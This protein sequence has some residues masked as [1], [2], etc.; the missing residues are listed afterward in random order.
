MRGM[1]LTKRQGKILNKIVEEYIELVEPVS[2][3]LLEKK[4]DFG[5]CPA[6]IRIEMQKLT[7]TGFISQPHTSAGRIP[8]DKGYRFFVDT[9]FQKGFL[10]ESYDSKIKNWVE[11]DR[12]D[13]VKFHQNLTKNL[14]S[15]SSN[16]VL[17]Y[18]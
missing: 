4:Y 1:E 10:K 6:T 17:T 14:D 5:V 15:F 16:L 12:E 3:K 9:L 11:D 7:D 8:T 13:T 2:S 18:I